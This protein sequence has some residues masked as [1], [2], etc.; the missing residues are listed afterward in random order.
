MKQF[1][2][3]IF[4]IIREYIGNETDYRMFMNCNKEIFQSIKYQTVY[5]RKTILLRLGDN[6]RIH[7]MFNNF[8]TL[9]SKVQN[10]SKQIGLYL[11][12]TSIDSIM[13]YGNL[14]DQIHMF[15]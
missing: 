8:Q 4:P 1:P 2:V 12:G 11:Y 6:D 7:D 14:F 15:K 9:I 5:F 13:V 10:K 3:E